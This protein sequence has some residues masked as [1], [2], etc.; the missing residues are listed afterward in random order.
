MLST[1]AVWSELLSVVAAAEEE[2]LKN[3]AD[4]VMMAVT[5]KAIMLFVLIRFFMF[6]SPFFKFFGVNVM[7]ITLDTNYKWGCSIRKMVYIYNYMSKTN[8]DY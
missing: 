6:F 1:T 8:T 5:E 4:K 2:S 7:S 3:V